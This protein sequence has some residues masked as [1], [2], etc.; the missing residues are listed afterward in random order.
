MSEKYKQFGGWL[1]FFYFLCIL[2]IFTSITMLFLLGIELFENKGRPVFE[3]LLE[4]IEIAIT[5]YILYLIIQVIQIREPKAPEFIEDKLFIM[6]IVAVGYFILHSL[7]TLPGEGWTMKNTIALAGSV[8]SM[9]W[10]AIWRTYFEKSE[11]VRIYY[12]LD[13]ND[14]ED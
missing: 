11:R 8:Q 3:V 6:F 1:K 13:E 12:K 5:L 9:I 7:F 10:A 4:G 14:D 2:N